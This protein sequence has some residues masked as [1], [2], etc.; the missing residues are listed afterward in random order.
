M[1]GELEL[2][3]G[4][5]RQQEE[6]ASPTMEFPSSSAPSD[7]GLRTFIRDTASGAVTFVVN[8]ELVAW[9]GPGLLVGAQRHGAGDCTSL[10]LGK[11]VRRRRNHILPARGKGEPME[12][13]CGL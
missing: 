3:E 5:L 12:W 9:G 13:C 10:L 4:D 2:S 6:G 1:P 7:S 11:K 8:S